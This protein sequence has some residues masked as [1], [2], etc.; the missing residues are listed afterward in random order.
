M[1]GEEEERREGYLMEGESG[2]ARKA[3]E[4]RRGEA[5]KA[6]KEGGNRRS[7]RV[8]GVR[9]EESSVTIECK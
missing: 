2:R 3:G 4:G 8:V 7:E 5:Q 9:V 6:K 1:E